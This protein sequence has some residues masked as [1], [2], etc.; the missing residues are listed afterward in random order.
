LCEQARDGLIEL[1]H[2]IVENAHVE[3]AM[4]I[5]TYEALDTARLFAAKVL[6]KEG[7]F[8]HLVQARI[9]GEGIYRWVMSSRHQVSAEEHRGASFT[10]P[11][12]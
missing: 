9:D 3:R 5:N 10:G 1:E 4:V 11:G 8:G 2:G 6:H 7:H 12:T